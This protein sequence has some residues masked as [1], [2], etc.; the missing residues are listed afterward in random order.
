MELIFTILLGSVLAFVAYQQWN[1]NRIRLRFDMYD[2]RYVIYKRVLEG[3]AKIKQK[4]DVDRKDLLLFLEYFNESYFLFYKRGFQLGKSDIPGYLQELMDK[5]REVQKINL[6]LR[7]NHKKISE[8]EGK[9]MNDR[10]MELV[11]D[12]AE[13]Q[14]KKARNVFATYLRIG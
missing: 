11:N 6:D 5:C 1:T 12:L 9:W 13:L 14:V 3:L 4:G 10:K 2:R 7:D 8:A